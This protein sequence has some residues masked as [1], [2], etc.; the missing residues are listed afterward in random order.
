[1]ST[2]SETAYGIA[3]AMHSEHSP[4]AIGRAGLVEELDYLELLHALQGEISDL[5]AGSVAGARA[6]GASWT[7]IGRALGNVSKQ[8]AQQRYGDAGRARTVAEHLAGTD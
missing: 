8:A 4:A 2:A 7:D 1:M 6:N 5:I 3:T